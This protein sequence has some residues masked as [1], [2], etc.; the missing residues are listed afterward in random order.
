MKHIQLAISKMVN[1]SS[2]L[3]VLASV[4]TALAARNP[5]KVRNEGAPAGQIKNVGGIDI[6]HSYPPGKN[7][8]TNAVIYLSDIF[9]IPLPQNKL[10]ADSIAAN[11]YLVLMPD[12][13]NG[14]PVALGEL[15][16][17]LNLT[18]WQALHPASETERIINATLSYMRKELK[19]KKIG[20]VGYCFGGKWVPRFLTANAGIDAGFIAHPSGLTEAEI[21]AIKWPLSIAA[22]TLDAAFNATAKVRAETILNTNNVTFQSNLYSSAPHGFAVRANL[23]VPHQAYAKQAAFVQAVTWFDAW[24]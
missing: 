16:A 17:G 10:L 20:G 7:A 9:G 19:V 3:L 21:R 24:L 2:L 11:N 4:G 8:P 6:Y 18:G 12:L 22:G 1:S 15:E 13:F 14:D 23:S 5:L